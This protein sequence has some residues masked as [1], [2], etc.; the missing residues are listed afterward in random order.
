MDAHASIHRRVE[1]RFP[2]LGCWSSASSLFHELT[3]IFIEDGGPLPVS[4]PHSLYIQNNLCCY[5]VLQS[6][7]QQSCYL[8]TH[9]Q[10]PTQIR[11]GGGGGGAETCPGS[12]CAA[13]K[14]S[15][16]TLSR[17]TFPHHKNLYCPSPLMPQFRTGNQSHTCIQAILFVYHTFRLPYASRACG[18]RENR[19]T[20][21]RE[22]QDRSVKTTSSCKHVGDA[23]YFS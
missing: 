23:P 10:T 9:P 15:K 2:C 4:M 1:T 11:G 7:S 13:V 14:T 12:H 22:C 17:V 6:V 18:H 21:A 3:S 8:R 19:P 5:Q 20:V 16:F